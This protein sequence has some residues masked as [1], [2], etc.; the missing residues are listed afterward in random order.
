MCSFFFLL[1]SHE[2]LNKLP[3]FYI[4]TRGLCLPHTD[5]RSLLAMYKF[6][7]FLCLQALFMR[8]EAESSATGRNRLML[9]VAVS[10]Y[11]TQIETSYQVNLIHK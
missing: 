4:E 11:K 3:I 6:E 5:M 8:F 9:T 7:F 2:K 1:T 10:G